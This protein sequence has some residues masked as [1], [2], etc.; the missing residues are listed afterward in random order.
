M[1]IK[2]RKK[3]AI[4]HEMIA[5]KYNGT[6]VVQTFKIGNI[7]TVAI[8]AKDH[9][10]T[11]SLKIKAKIIGIPYENCYQL[12]TKYGTLTNFYLTN[13]L[14]LVPWELLNL[15]LACI[16]ISKNPFLTIMFHAATTLRSPILHVPVKYKCKNKCN[17]QRCNCVKAKV[18]YKQYCHFGH[19]NYF[20]LPSTIAKQTEIP[21]V[22]QSTFHSKR[23]CG[24]LTPT[25]STKKPLIN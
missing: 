20:N 15:V 9:A 8:L 25:K 17:T 11:D 14:N 19:L 5:K 18:K 2:I 7:F 23:K 4:W 1:D 22:S 24:K 10:V 12:K 3:Q 21:I 13:K 6:H 16:I